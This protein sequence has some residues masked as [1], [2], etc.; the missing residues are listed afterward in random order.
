MSKQVPGVT[1]GTILKNARSQSSAVS[2]CV[3][4]ESIWDSLF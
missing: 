1:P 2:P 3:R 4:Y